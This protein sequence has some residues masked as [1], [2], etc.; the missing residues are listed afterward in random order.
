MNNGE[1]TIRPDFIPFGKPNFSEEEINALINVMRTGWIGLGQQVLSFEEELA[2]YIGAPNLISVNSCTSALFLSLLVSGVKSGDE[3]I[4]PSLTWCST[5][6][7]A[8]YLG[9]KPVFCDVDKKT[10]C[11]TPEDL[12]SKISPRTKAVMVVHMA[13]YAVDVQELRDALPPHIVIIED[14]A[15]ALGSKFE[16][17]NYVGTSGNLT[18][19]SFYAN[20]NLSTGD[21]GAISL[22]DQET[23]DK[24]RSLRNHALSADAWKRFTHPECAMMPGISELGYKM[25]YTDLQASIGRVQLKRQ[26][27][28]RNT[29]QV[30]AEKYYKEL[31]ELNINIKFQNEIL[32]DNHS[33]HLFQ[34]VLPVENLSFTRNQMLLELRRR[35]IG[36]G[37]HYLPLHKMPLYST[38]GDHLLPNTDYLADRLLTLPISASMSSSDVDYIISHVKDIFTRGLK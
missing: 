22:Y 34:I 33:R 15:H 13:G 38:C 1:I 17:G 11:I 20:K 19:F 37:I 9:A 18:C 26:A 2:A 24:I 31:S 12:H 36:A 29:R 30:I 32:S 21:G 28:F 25:N 35:N 8:M 16:N 3:V 5:A 4:C 7:A 14:A 6:N 27:E 10:F 23:A